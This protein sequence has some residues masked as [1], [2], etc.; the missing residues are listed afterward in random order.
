MCKE[1]ARTGCL[2]LRCDSLLLCNSCGR[3]GCLLLNQHLL[4]LLLHEKSVCGWI[5]AAST[6]SGQ[7]W[8][9]W[10]LKLF[11]NHNKRFFDPTKEFAAVAPVVIAP[12]IT[13]TPIGRAAFM[14][15]PFQ[16]PGAVISGAVLVNGA[17]FMPYMFGVTLQRSESII[18]KKDVYKP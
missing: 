8:M 7:E 11:A 1:I 16:A 4:L 14:P 2:R 18:T 6:G 5:N 10:C 13:P 12:G 17:A 3:C 9:C 15:M